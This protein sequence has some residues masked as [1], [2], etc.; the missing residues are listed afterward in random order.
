MANPQAEKGHMRIANEIWNEMIRR[1][2]TLRQK[3]ILDLILRLSWGCGQK[4]AVI[5]QMKDFE[6]CGVRREHVTLE[7]NQLVEMKVIIWDK[8]RNEYSFNKDYDQWQVTPVSGWSMDRFNDL[9]SMNLIQSTVTKT[10]TGFPKMK[11]SYRKKRV[12]DLPKGQSSQGSIPCGSRDEDALKASSLKQSF[13]ELT[14]TNDMSYPTFPEQPEEDSH[15][16][17]QVEQH[18]VMRRGKGLTVNPI[19][20]DEINKLIKNGVPVEIIKQGIDKA[21]ADFKEKKRP[22]EITTFKYCIGPITDLWER[23]KSTE[24]KGLQVIQGGAQIENGAVVYTAA[25]K[26]GGNDFARGNG[27]AAFEQTNQYSGLF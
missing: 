5:P 1:K 22:G 8:N 24:L 11:L 10:V 20:L 16:V 13:K 7:I 9:L 18:F 2:L 23:T 19:D 17:V 14:T 25:R 4:S 27:K 15:P 21:F 26:K 12:V 6:L 3:N